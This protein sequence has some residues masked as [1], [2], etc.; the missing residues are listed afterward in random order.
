MYSILN[1]CTVI[2]VNQGRWGSLRTNGPWSRMAAVCEFPAYRSRTALTCAR[3]VLRCPEATFS[4]T[5]LEE[6]KRSHVLL[7]LLLLTLLKKETKLG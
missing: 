3:N 2:L 1:L 4:V 5:P 7:L 6:M